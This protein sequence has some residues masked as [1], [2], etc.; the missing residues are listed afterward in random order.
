MRKSFIY[1]SGYFSTSNTFLC[2]SPWWTT[3][4]LVSKAIPMRA[5]VQLGGKLARREGT[6]RAECLAGG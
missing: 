6:Y 5:S 2:F 4:T 1:I 3:E